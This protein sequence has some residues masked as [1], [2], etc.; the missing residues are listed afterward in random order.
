[1][2]NKTIKLA[3]ISGKGGV[4]KSMVCA[5]FCLL[6]SQK[7]HIVA[8]DCDVDAPNLAIWLNETSEWQRTVPVN[9]FSKVKIDYDKCISCDVC[10][11]KCRFGAIDKKNESKPE[12]NNFL[13]DGCGACE[14]VCPYT[15][16]SPVSTQSGEVKT[17]QTKYGFPLV[18]G[19]LFSGEA[20]T[21]KVI[22]EVKKEADNFD[23]ALQ[24]IDS[25]PGIGAPV[26]ATLYNV[27]F[28]V[29]ISEPTPSG[30]SDVIRVLEVVK[31]HN[32][33][34]GL[35]INKWDLNIKEADKISELAGS[36]LLGKISY[37][38][39]VMKATSD[40]IP[41]METQLKVADEIKVIYNKL[42][43]R[44]TEEAL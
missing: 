24:I 22:N 10:I 37:D 42:K 36:N 33:P 34:W 28:T 15:A 1:M 43:A 12:I 18:L 44:I 23:S 4:G 32:I 14:S 40:F 5:S 19:H 26:L 3:V 41:I 6:S 16:I 17:K 29:V 27:N 8:V 7:N 20:A 13:C 2:N 31:K 35:I 25:P 30:F 21:N 9:T 38:N 39:G 11:E